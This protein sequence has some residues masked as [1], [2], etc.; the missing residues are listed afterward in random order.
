MLPSEK[1]LQFDALSH[2]KKYTDRFCVDEVP[3]AERTETASNVAD[4]V[5]TELAAFVPEA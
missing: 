1:L 5:L 3:E 2:Y 4:W